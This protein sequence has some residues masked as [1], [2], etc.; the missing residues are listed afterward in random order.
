MS[1]SVISPSPSHIS[2]TKSSYNSI[3]ETEIKKLTVVNAVLDKVANGVKTGCNGAA[4][5]IMAPHRN[6]ECTEPAWSKWV[7][8]KMEGEEFHA[9]GKA[10]P[11]NWHG[12]GTYMPSKFA[13]LLSLILRVIS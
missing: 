3:L 1:E 8:E 13:I 2:P 9:V 7:D 12:G 10:R 6:D 11:V 4:K 5:I